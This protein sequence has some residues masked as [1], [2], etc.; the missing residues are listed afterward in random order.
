MLGLHVL[1]NVNYSNIIHKVE[2]QRVE[3]V[4]SSTPSRAEIMRNGTHLVDSNDI[5]EKGQRLDLCGD[6]V[7]KHLLVK[8]GVGALGYGGLQH[9]GVHDEG[10]ELSHL[11]VDVLLVQ[12]VHQHHDDRQLSQHLQGHHRLRDQVVLEC[13]MGT[14]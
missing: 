11:V 10:D 9:D 6:E 3:T 8:G 5:S 14:C 7:N 12:L 13:G 1:K 2:K 4:P